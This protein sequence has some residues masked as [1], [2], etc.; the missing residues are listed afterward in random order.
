[1][2]G[3]VGIAI[4]AAIARG[5]SHDMPAALPSPQAESGERLQLA[6]ATA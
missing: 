4:Q 1:M 3:D 2:T 5:E 6:Q